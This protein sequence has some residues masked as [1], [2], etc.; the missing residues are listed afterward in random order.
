[1][2]RIKLIFIFCLSVTCSFSQSVKTTTLQRPKLVVGIV[3]DQM[4][5]DY[6]Y[7]Y[8]DRYTSN[9]FKRL[10]NEGFSC[11]NTMINYLPSYTA[12]GHT[13]VFTGS[14]PAIHGIAGNDWIDQ[15]TGK[16][17]YC[18]SDST[19]E[20][21]GAPN[22]RDGRMSPRNLL[23][24]TV[25]DE[26]RLATN[27]QSRVV[28]VSLK[29]RASILPAG[30]AANAAFWLDDA[31]GHFITSTYYMKE[32]P[33]WATK[34]NN[35]NH[36]AQLIENGW[37]TLY[38][39]NTYKESD[40]DVKP[41]EGILPGEKTPSFPHDIKNV[42]TKS[43]GSFRTTPFG[44][45]LTLQFAKEAVEGYHLG[46]G[47]ATDF[48]TIN[49]AST[50]Y[51]GHMFGPNSIEVEDTYLR[52]DKDLADF[53][54]MLDAKV[55]KGQYLIFLTA[56]HGAAHSV[57]FMKEHELPADFWFAKQTADTLNKI[58]EDKFHKTG[59]VRAVMNY[60]VDFDLAKIAEN[61]MDFD[62]IKKASIDYLQKQ[63]GVL[64]VADMSM[65][66]K[67]SI[68]N[69]IREMMING[70][71][72]K[73]SGQIQIVLDAGWFDAYAKTGTTHGSWYSY[74]THIPLLWYGWHV[75]PGKLNREVYMTDISP[76]VAALLHIQMPSGSVGHVIEEITK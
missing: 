63:P 44:N 65:I 10:I 17:H 12:V 1:M 45:T 51:V 39:I 13:T 23:V 46:R 55:G 9:G 16:S 69:R 37:N 29:D 14:V 15:L 48:L 40:E 2:K 49:L 54:N 5:W 11:D 73:R 27:F 38:P 3:V 43:K 19:V 70:Y 20:S 59:L 42:Y 67:Y 26:L 68:P 56:D 25:T 7:R 64:F 4:R 34:F 50:D 30:H 21:V 36:I 75:K 31:S 76:T 41:Y 74:D 33:S 22:A 47:A 66:G 8:Y 52:L 28:G 6:L 57:G 58:L 60:Q 62:A 61:N 71:N 18:T 24:T 53:F 72:F 32:L 35:E